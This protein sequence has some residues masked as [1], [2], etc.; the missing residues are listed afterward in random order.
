MKSKKLIVSNHHWLKLM[1]CF[2]N[3]ISLTKLDFFYWQIL[4][5]KFERI[6]Y[7]SYDMKFI[8]EETNITN[9]KSQE[10]TENS[11]DI[12]HEIFYTKMNIWR[13][14]HKR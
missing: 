10:A 12:H 9:W 14:I 4:F 13:L 6:Q 8:N 11:R 7:F 1:I 2:K 5:S 3:R